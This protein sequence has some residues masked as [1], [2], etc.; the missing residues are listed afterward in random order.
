MNIPDD[1]NYTSELEKRIETLE[2]L[3]EGND[4]VTASNVLD[5]A[6]WRV[7]KCYQHMQ[8]SS[9]NSWNVDFSIIPAKGICISVGR[10]CD[11]T[12]TIPW[13]E[14]GSSIAIENY[15]YKINRKINKLSSA[16]GEDF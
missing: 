8:G 14:C 9:W 13:E 3:L 6:R 2:S 1:Q 7:M 10:E 15:L 4:C 12:I 11:Y 16:Y 5:H